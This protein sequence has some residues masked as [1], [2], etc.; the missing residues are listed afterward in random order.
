MIIDWILINFE[1]EKC[2]EKSLEVWNYLFHLATLYCQDLYLI[3]CRVQIL[4]FIY[5]S[6]LDGSMK[7]ISE[8]DPGHFRCWYHWNHRNELATLYFW[9]S[10]TTWHHCPRPGAVPLSVSS[11]TETRI[12]PWEPSGVRS[13]CAGWSVSAGR[14]VRDPSKKFGDR[15]MEQHTESPLIKLFLFIAWQTV[16]DRNLYS[17]RMGHQHRTWLLRW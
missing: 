10:N 14:C 16:V 15:R 4:S 1:D 5:F 2:K 8:I 6:S 9:I 13:V 7:K 11:P 17:T 3:T 12:A